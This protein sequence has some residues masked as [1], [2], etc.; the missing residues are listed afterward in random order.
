MCVGGW[1]GG[2]SGLTEG[3]PSAVSSLEVGRRIGG[4]NTLVGIHRA[5]SLCLSLPR[6][7]CCLAGLIPTLTHRSPS[8]P[9]CLPSAALLKSPA[10]INHNNIQYTA[11]AEWFYLLPPPRTMGPYI[12]TTRGISGNRAINPKHC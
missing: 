7:Y 10:L 5:H 6:T 9:P 3:V 11:I 2:G 1:G 4:R 8:L 12:F